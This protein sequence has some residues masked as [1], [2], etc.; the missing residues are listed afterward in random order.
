MATVT[1]NRL[2]PPR[3]NPAAFQLQL[4]SDYTLTGSATGLS[5]TN[6]T[7]G[8]ASGATSFTVPSGGM[9]GLA[10]YT[11]YFHL[12]TAGTITFA[13]LDLMIDGA[14][15]GPEV[16]WNPANVAAGAR[17]TASQSWPFAL[18]AGSHSFGLRAAVTLSSGQV[19]LL[20]THT[21]LSILLHP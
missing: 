17:V 7:P 1:G 18:A 3:L 8:Y 4:A 14:W 13:T 20:A 11:G 19:R 10:V 5:L 16:V 12:T 21:N 9:T 15:V 6:V 2:P